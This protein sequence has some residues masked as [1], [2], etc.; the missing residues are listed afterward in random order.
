MVRRQHGVNCGLAA[1]LDGPAN[2]PLTVTD[3]PG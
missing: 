3:C 2:P 1:P